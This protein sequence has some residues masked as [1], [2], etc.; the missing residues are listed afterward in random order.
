MELKAIRVK[1]QYKKVWQLNDWQRNHLAW[2][3]DNNTACGLLTAAS[4]ARGELLTNETLD[5]IFIWAGQSERSAKI[6]AHKVQ[7]FD[8]KTFRKK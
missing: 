2:R 7:T 8:P 4:I 3:L 1:K 6:L 5:K